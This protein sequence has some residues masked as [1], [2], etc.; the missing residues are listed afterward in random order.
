MQQYGIDVPTFAITYPGTPGVYQ[1]PGPQIGKSYYFVSCFSPAGSDEKAAADLSAA[2]DKNGFSAS[3]GDVNFVAGWVAGQLVTEAPGKLGPE[4]TSES[5]VA[6]L[7]GGFGI[8]SHGLWCGQK[9]R[10]SHCG[11]PLRRP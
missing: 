3:K 1:S 2:A 10:R 5:L 11:Q 4:P 9:G 6:M 8:D 7:S